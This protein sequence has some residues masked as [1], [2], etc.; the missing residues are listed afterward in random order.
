MALTPWNIWWLW[1]PQSGI[2]GS[3]KCVF[4]G[5]RYLYLTPQDYTQISS[6]N[7]VH[8]KHIEDEGESR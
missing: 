6:Q 5:F 2:R 7:S 3:L 4:K 8:C 1:S